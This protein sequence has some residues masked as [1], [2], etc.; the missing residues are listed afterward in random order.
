VVTGRVGYSPGE[1]EDRVRVGAFQLERK[2]GAG[3]MGEIWLAEHVGQGIPAAVKFD[4]HPPDDTWREAFLAEVRRIAELDH[5]NVVHLFDTG[6]VTA[7]ESRATGGVLAEGM[8]W[9]AMELAR[10][11]AVADDGNA[12]QTWEEVLHVTSSLLRA[13]AHAH[14]RGIVHRDIKPGNLL[15]AGPRSSLVA[16]P[17]H[18]L[19]AR[20]VLSDF[21]IGHDRSRPGWMDEQSVGTPR[22]M[23]PEMIEANWRDQGPWTDLYQT[24]ILLW[25]LVC[26][27]YP[28]QQ[29]KAVQLYR[30]HLL[31]PL[32]DFEPV[33]DVPA[34]LEE[35]VR[36]MLEKAWQDRPS[37]CQDVLD[38]LDALGPPVPGSGART[39]GLDPD[40]EEVPT[41]VEAPTVVAGRT[42]TD[43]GQTGHTNRSLSPGP[44]AFVMDLGLRGAGLGLW[45]LR[46][47][48]L[49]GRQDERERLWDGLKR[50]QTSGEPYAL[51]LRG[52]AG[53]GKSRLATWV[54]QEAHEKGLARVL[55]VAHH[56]TPDDDHGLPGMYRRELRLAGLDRDEAAERFATHLQLEEAGRD[57][58][59]TWVLGA[60]RPEDREP[61]VSEKLAL[62][63][64]CL[65]AWA[66]E[67]PVLLV[68]DDAHHGAMALRLVGALLR[69]VRRLP[70]YV[71]FAVRDDLLAGRPEEV[72][73]LQVLLD[74]P[75]ADA[76]PLGPLPPGD[77]RQLV[78]KMLGLEGALA[79]EVERRTAGNP[80]FA[81]QLVNSWVR[82]GELVVGP[83]GFHLRGGLPDHLPEDLLDVWRARVDELARSAA[84]E[85]LR[86]LEL[87]AMAGTDVALE[88]WRALCDRAG[89]PLR[90]RFVGGLLRTHV[91]RPDA[92]MEHVTFAHNGIREAILQRVRASGWEPSL[93]SVVADHL[94]DV[95]GDRARL[96]EVLLLAGRLEEATRPML[97]TIEDE[98]AQGDLR[99]SRWLARLAETLT[100]LDAPRDDE[101][102]GMLWLNWAWLHRLQ[103]QREEADE[104]AVRAEAS[105]RRHGWKSVLG[106]ALRE[107]GSTALDS[108]EY[109][110]AIGFLQEAEAVLEEAGRPESAAWCRQKLGVAF[111]FTGDFELAEAAYQSCLDVFDAE[112]KSWVYAASP[113]LALAQLYQKQGRL[114]EALAHAEEARWRSERMGQHTNLAHIAMLEGEVA[115]Y[116]GDLEAADAHYRRSAEL[117]EA[118]HDPT[119]VVPTLNL[120]VVGV[121]RGQFA[122]TRALMDTLLKRLEDG[123]A[124]IYTA[125]TRSVLVACTAAL[126][127][128]WSFTTHHHALTAFL[129]RTGVADPDIVKL[130]TIAAE[131]A[132]DDTVRERAEQLVAQQQARLRS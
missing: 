44:S 71:V 25:R 117:Y 8:P 79:A 85:D 92:R 90:P 120:G 14:A 64:R 48:P 56:P 50:V 66:E 22:F 95:G 5:P 96:A 62:L 35:L 89:S 33:M 76:L 39:L 55:H 97:D 67:R 47:P 73:R 77:Q 57:L 53:V 132:V 45:G 12:P 60:A 124:P 100:A 113:W 36:W 7:E 87:A 128:A 11:G 107:A 17:D 49:V 121:L 20:V 37:F 91:L 54:A 108:S 118:F 6:L 72:R 74:G 129:E 42:G 58:L 38:R 16:E 34:G 109:R 127:D 28:F 81:V 21:G 15:L 41:V 31:L 1:E 51:V 125:Y 80:A 52:A 123:G 106:W 63:R 30:A 110:E 115:R 82:S 27:A 78:R 46:P 126:N 111:D 59:I 114:D 43:T 98:L 18:V 65:T 88:E 112:P 99:S 13:L 130:A 23:A 24:G 94:L 116:R 32:P 101:R 83:R 119:S 68:V 26:D 10:G 105:A 93:A 122:E 69:R 29:R 104:L 19:E 61:S 103:G 3:G 4:L 75:R 86:T 9:L 70:V 84:P 40:D 102:W 2:I 131:E